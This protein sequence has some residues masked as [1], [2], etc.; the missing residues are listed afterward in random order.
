[1]LNN[2]VGYGTYQTLGNLSV[3]FDG[4]SDFS[5]FTRTLD[6]DTG[7]H[8]S[9]W[10]SSGSVFTTSIFCS[11]PATS[12][13]Y[14]LNS[15]VAL[16]SVTISL[17]N[18]LMDSSLVNTTCGTGYTRLRGIT[19]LDIGLEFD[20]VARTLGNTTTTCLNDTG[21]LLITPAAGQTSIALLFSAESNY[22]QTKGNVQDDYSFQGVDPGPIV[23][24]RLDR[25]VLQ[26]YDALLQD[27]IA[28]YSS[29]MGSFTLDLPNTSGSSGLETADL[30]ARYTENTTDPFLESLLFDY[31][32]HLLVSSSREGSLPANLQGRWAESLQP[33]WSGDYHANI[34]LQMNYWGAD[35][36]GL[37]ELSRPVFEYIADT[38][39]TRGAETAQLLYNGSGWVTHNEMNIFG[40]T[41]MKNGAEWADCKPPL[42]SL[43]PRLSVS[44]TA[45]S[46]PQ[47]QHQQHG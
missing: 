15:D 17:V 39:A 13:V 9:S 30:V 37:S 44:L 20:S 10:T 27:H 5:N 6:L 46:T 19:Q 47:T 22:D 28:D 12:C 8:T 11:H 14:R 21:A 16:G 7:V 4:V 26:G 45:A 33:A 35:Q 24:E 43:P 36:T 34:N 29:L 38:W 32:R 18:L 3:T 31:S 42:L 40:Y 25:A 1:M 23:E 2:G 41:G